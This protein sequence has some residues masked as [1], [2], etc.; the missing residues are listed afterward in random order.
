M[1]G[2]SHPPHLSPAPPSLPLST[3]PG[4]P[5]HSSCN[6]LGALGTQAASSAWQCSSLFP[7]P[8]LPSEISLFTRHPYNMSTSPN[9][10]NLHNG[11]GEISP[12][13]PLEAGL[14]AKFTPKRL[15]GEMKQGLIYESRGF[16]EMVPKQWTRQATF[17]LF[18]QGNNKSVRNW[19]NK[20]T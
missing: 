9:T 2:Y 18:R 8:R 16:M 14:I 4:E 13:I 15:M 6:K 5:P 20:E 19:Q 12:S 10:L 17:T 11:E 3:G 7:S 1:V